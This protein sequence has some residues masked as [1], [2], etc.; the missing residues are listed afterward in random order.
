MFS[1]NGYYLL[2]IYCIKIGQ[3]VKNQW[4]NCLKKVFSFDLNS[5]TFQLI[6]KLFTKKII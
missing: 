2:I 5:L 1:N 4:K 6:K 3:Q